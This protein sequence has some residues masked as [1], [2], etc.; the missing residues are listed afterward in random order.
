LFSFGWDW[1]PECT[2]HCFLLG[3]LDA[4]KLFA[5]LAGP[6]LLGFCVTLGIPREVTILLPSTYW[7]HH[8]MA[9]V[10]FAMSR[11]LDVGPFELA[12]ATT[13]GK[14]KYT[15]RANESEG[16]HRNH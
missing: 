8:R 6:F 9:Q 13:V 11:V 5:L 4:L 15:L 14:S 10:V 16:K 3:I 2:S 7:C 12:A 1:Q